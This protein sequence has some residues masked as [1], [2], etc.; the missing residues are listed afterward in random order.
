MDRN[1]GHGLCAI[2]KVLHVITSLR[3]RFEGCDSRLE[4]GRNFKLDRQT[5]W[6]NFHVPPHHMAMEQHEQRS[7]A[8]KNHLKVATNT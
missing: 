5:F 8:S 2:R 1:G 7:K 6:A 3:A 4:S